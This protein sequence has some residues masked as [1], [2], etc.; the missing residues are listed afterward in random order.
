MK[1]I[2]FIRRLFAL[3]RKEFYQLLRDK[4]S[5]L[6]GIV[7]RH[8]LSHQEK[9]MADYVR[10]IATMKS[11]NVDAAGCVVSS[12]EMEQVMRIFAVS[13]EKFPGGTSVTAALR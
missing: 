8:R 4:S 1:E 6:L 7:M 2:P 10:E 11:K 5:L 3:T 13:P 12:K 9:M